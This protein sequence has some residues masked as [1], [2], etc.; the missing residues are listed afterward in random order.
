LY[1]SG[2]S[3]STN[4]SFFWALNAFLPFPENVAIFLRTINC[5]DEPGVPLT[6]R[7]YYTDAYL[8]EFE[9][10]VTGRADGGARVYLDRTAF[11]PTSGGQLH[12]TGQLGGVEVID[13]VD[14]GDRVAHL[15]AAP[16]PEGP[17]RGRL[18]WARRFDHM[19]QHTGQH[20]LSA[21][22]ADLLGYPTVSVHFGKDISTLDLEASQLSPEQVRLAER[23]ANEVVVQ[24]RAVKVSF[25]EADEAIGLRKAPP[26]AGTLR[27]ITI[28][29]LDRSACG[30]THVSS[31]GEIGAILVR[32]VE[33]V[34]KGARLEFLCGARAVQRARSDFDLLSGLA[35]QF[36]ASADEL[37]GLIAAERA[38]LKES[39]STRRDLEAQL[40]LY[41]AKELYAGA[42]L[43]ASGIRRV[44]VRQAGGSVN[45][46]KGVAQAFASMPRGMFVAAT[47]NPPAVLLAT[48]PDSGIDAANVLKG[49]LAAVGG[50]GGGSTTMAQ[51][52][53]PGPEQ[54]EQVLAPLA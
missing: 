43:D 45:A 29:E 28:E 13:V 19:Q 21:V 10:S 39:V 44:L 11:Y 3:F 37:P 40:D 36:S 46:L 33:R 6:D 5:I 47:D 4:W 9:A 24:N 20:L 34:R 38:E 26:R 49:L 53:V 22:L 48:S 27:I 15:L 14:E 35:A 42:T 2:V 52:T 51:G 18:D 41:Y 17:I 32:K 8:R 23:R 31:T 16:L 25:E 50:R 12:D 1:W 54:L 7:L 30:G